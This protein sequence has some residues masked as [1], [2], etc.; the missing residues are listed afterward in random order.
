MVPEPIGYEGKRSCLPFG[1]EGCLCGC[2]R[3]QARL[4]LGLAFLSLD[5]GLDQR[6]DKPFNGKTGVKKEREGVRKWWLK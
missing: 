3:D 1:K 2:D 5:L 4:S 6:Q